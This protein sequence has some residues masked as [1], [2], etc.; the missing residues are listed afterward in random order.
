MSTERETLFHRG[1]PG[2]AGQMS[3]PTTSIGSRGRWRAKA[4]I[5]AQSFG[6]GS[7]G[8][9]VFGHA[10]NRSQ[11]QPCRLKRRRLGTGR[12]I[13]VLLKLSKLDRNRAS[14]N[15]YEDPQRVAEPV[16]QACSQDIVIGKSEQTLPQCQQ[17]ACEIPAVNRRNV[18]GQQRLQR[19]RVVPVIEVA[20]V[21]LQSFHCAEG[22]R[23][24]FDES[25][26]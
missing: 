2:T 22:V 19:L 10:A 20:P 14:R 12:Q 7:G 26:G 21:T 3:A 4:G 24:T 25:S 11:A 8:G 13:Q 17:M 16:E 6:G 1:H 23:C 18:E 15:V 5:G 9:H